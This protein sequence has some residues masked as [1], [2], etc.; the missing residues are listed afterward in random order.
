MPNYTLVANSTFQPFTYQELMMPIERQNQY[1]EKL[2]E[3]YDKMSSQADVLEAMGSSD[4]DKGSNT[5]NRYKAYSDNLRKERDN[6][7]ANGLNFESRQRLSDL[8]RMYNTEI[9][10]IQNA[11]QKREQEAQLQMKARMDA[12]ARGIDIRFSRDAANSSLDS[13]MQNPNQTFQVINGQQITNEVANQFKGL[14]SQVQSDGN[15]NYFIKG[16]PLSQIEYSIITQKGMDWNHYQ[17]FINNPKD[18]RFA[19]IRGIIENTLNAHGIKNFDENTYRDM[20]A[21]GA[22]GVAAG[23]GARD[24]Q[25]HTDE[26]QKMALDDMYK[27]RAEERQF[28]RAVA[29][30]REKAR[31]NGT[32]NPAA[33]DNVINPLPLRSQQ[34]ISE[35]NKDIQEF[36]N[37]GYVKQ[38]PVTGQYTMTKEGW[39]EYRTKTANNEKRQAL[40]AAGQASDSEAAAK[41]KKLPDTVPSKFRTFMDELNGGKSFVDAKGNALPGWGPNRA[42]NLF[43][44]GI[45]K[46]QEGSYDTYHSTEYDRQLAS[47]Y[48]NEFTKQLWSAAR[49]SNGKKVLDVVDYNGKKG[50]KQGKAL[51]SSDLKGYTVTNV[52]YSKYGNTAI[53]QKDGEEPIRVKIPKGVNLGAETNVQAAIANADDYGMILGRGKRPMVLDG[54]IVR[55]AKGE[56]M[57]TS[58]NLT[59]E[60]RAAFERYQRDAL[61]EM[62]SY[63]SQFVVPSTTKNDEYN[64]FAF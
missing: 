47:A 39:K 24:V 27:Q 26:A 34:E 7:F 49:M 57:F 36:I 56:I 2:A 58:E 64:P 44:S 32:Q 52:R 18:S 53:L 5:Y 22:Q 35:K 31:I 23:V 9:V 40:L 63:G 37:K 30:E 20:F 54:R 11:W 51:D 46:Y 3:E 43:S 33:N 10:P 21:Y 12:A 45:V 1:F 28:N 8:R 4:L 14:A 13:Y 61:N 38:D 55:N 17:D 48:G 59:P 29:L 41:A 16:K 60:D 6:L 42:G 15:G 62:S 19:N 50:W 25:L